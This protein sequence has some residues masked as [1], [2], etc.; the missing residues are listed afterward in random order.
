MPDLSNYVSEAIDKSNN[1]YLI[2]DN[3]LGIA[4]DDDSIV[5]NGGQNTAANGGIAFG[6]GTK[7][8]SANQLV[9]GEYN[10]EDST[11]Q[12]SFIVGKGT[13]STRSNAHTID[14]SG[15][16]YFS[17]TVKAQSPDNSSPDPNDLVTVDYL[18][19]H[20]GGGGGGSVTPATDTNLG[21]V[22]TNSTN[23]ITLDSS[24][25]LSI[26]GR[27][28]LVTYTLSGTTYSCNKTF[29][30]INT[31][32]SGGYIVKAYFETDNDGLFFDLY[33]IDITNSSYIKFSNQQG[34]LI[35]II[36]HASS[37]TI[38]LTQT[39]LIDNT[40][41]INGKQL[42]QNIALTGTNINTSDSNTTKISSTIS[43]INST[44]NN[45]ISQGASITRQY[46]SHAVYNST[47]NTSY[48]YAGVVNVN[49][50]K[51]SGFYLN[52]CAGN[53]SAN[54]QGTR[55]LNSIFIPVQM[56]VDLGNNV[57]SGIF[58]CDYNNNT[59]YG[60]QASFKLVS[61]Q[62]KYWV[63]LRQSNSDAAA[64]LYRVM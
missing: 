33:D 47:S 62:I 17:G 25:K 20:G 30:E 38:T 51:Y 45:K 27:L 18:N 15:N 16:A 64:V 44:L 53:S 34:L 3:R 2:R 55:V 35:R 48:N 5:Q 21:G 63:G 50:S 28:F 29:A 13:S 11:N 24:Y 58:I 36:E 4:S 61:N 52:I 41:T 60:A 10:V 54:P 37:G 7:A 49:V 26:S 32:L 39:T 22:R 42:N 23:G 19:T 43:T 59:T 8:S 31:A 6:T 40:I 46:T 14:K 12:Y 9:I 56:I 57:A 1:K